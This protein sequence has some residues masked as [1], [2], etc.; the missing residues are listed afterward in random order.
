MALNFQN[1][2]RLIAGSPAEAETKLQALLDASSA[3]GL[4]PEKERLEEV[5]NRFFKKRR[6]R[7]FESLKKKLNPSGVAA[8]SERTRR[9]ERI[10]KLNDFAADL[11]LRFKELS[12]KYIFQWVMRYRP[13]IAYVF[14]E[15]D[16]KI[17]E[18]LDLSELAEIVKAE[19]ARHT[20]E[21][22]RKG[23]DYIS[24][25]GNDPDEP[26]IK[27]L[28]GLSQLLELPLEYYVNKLR[29]VSSGHE[30][31]AL[32]TT[33]S[34]LIEGVLDGYRSCQFGEESG[35]QWLGAYPRH[36]SFVLGFLTANATQAVAEFLP[37]SDWSESLVH[38]VDPIAAYFDQVVSSSSSGPFPLPAVCIHERDFGRLKLSVE[39]VGSK[40][41]SRLLTIHCYLSGEKVH[42]RVERVADG[43]ISLILAPFPPDLWQRV[44]TSDRLRTTAVNCVRREADSL[45]RTRV[46]VQELL[47]A[48]VARR[49][50]G[51]LRV[52]PLKINWA[53]EF[54][55][56]DPKLMSVY[57][58]E[59]KSVKKLLRE[60]EHRTGARLWCSVRRSGKTT[61]CY[62][63]ARAAA[64]STVVVQTCDWAGIQDEVAAL[65]Y[66][67]VQ[68]C[69]SDRSQ[70]PNDFV[71]QTIGDATGLNT[72][73]AGR[74]ILVLDEYE[75]LFDRMRTAIGNDEEIRYT[76]V[77]PLLDQ[78]AAFAREHLLVLIGQRPDAQY[79]IMDQNQLVP[80]IEQDHFP[81][82]GH[83]SGSQDSELVQLLDRICAE[84]AEF[85]PA[86]VD[87]IKDETGGHPWLV[88]NLMVDLFDWLIERKVRAAGLRLTR[89]EFDSFA[90]ARLTDDRIRR[91]DYYKFFCRVV[92]D[93]LGDTSRERTPWIY[94]TCSLMRAASLH[95]REGFVLPSG[96]VAS[97]LADVY[98]AA[99][100]PFDAD[101]LI[102][103]ACESNFLVKS[104]GGVA[105]RIRLLGRICRVARPAVRI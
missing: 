24:S 47:D 28:N 85:D 80:Y 1:I 82:F 105:P 3:E 52:S 72:D 5:I 104:D 66:S 12:R 9:Q 19:I 22:F 96:E 26:R 57:R 95:D 4:L 8:E 50:K 97:V 36:W 20:Q 29:R 32:R 7:L 99:G 74:F 48:E 17:V 84:K 54:P 45:N 65:F 77:Q 16:Q 56:R 11:R 70:L 33:S 68:R 38:S 18:G 35:A 6:T 2:E 92:D 60:F 59:R 98:A 42:E 25:D 40:Q 44:Q 83:K 76:V 71:L 78:L 55:L 14:R 37:R 53:A 49:V 94:A 13:A 91:V 21:I 88:V 79:I 41:G 61:A 27:S 43:S 62:D 23:Y 100:R 31:A 73:L 10:Q 69:L 67:R 81:L 86:F 75:T 89:E 64:S 102:D 103:E 34:A 39:V 51:T 87:A 30:A 63:L 101:D 58:V 90:E 46:R 15:V 93:A